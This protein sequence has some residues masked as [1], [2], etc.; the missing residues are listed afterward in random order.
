MFEAQSHPLLARGRSQPV[1]KF[2]VRPLCH[3]S[4]TGHPDMILDYGATMADG[5]MGGMAWTSMIGMAAVS[6]THL[7][8][9]TKRIL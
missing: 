4:T 6:Y 8:L 7:T 9:P 2:F 5:K 3:V 1:T